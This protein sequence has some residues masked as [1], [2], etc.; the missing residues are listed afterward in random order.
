MI[1]GGLGGFAPGEW[2]DDTSMAVAIAEVAATGADLR[3]TEALDAIARGFRRWYDDGPADIGIQTSRVLGAAGPDP[4]AAAMR[5]EAYALHAETGR[6][7]GNGS[8]MRTG[9]G[10]AR[11]PRR[12]RR[13]WRRRRGR[14]AR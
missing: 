4:T 8:L 5:T 7:G 1:G 6:T 12:R 14:S 10:G 9:A 11:P 2:T 3:T 13:R